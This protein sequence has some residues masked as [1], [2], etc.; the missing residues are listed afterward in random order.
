MLRVWFLALDSLS[1]N[2]THFSWSWDLGQVTS[3]LGAS[4]F[5]S[6]NGQAIFLYRLI[7]RIQCNHSHKARRTVSGTQEG[8]HKRQP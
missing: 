4:V 6:A 1:V 8:L 7:V 5:S 3:P 2:M